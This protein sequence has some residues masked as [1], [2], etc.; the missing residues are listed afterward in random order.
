MISASLRTIFT[1]CMAIALV[2]S[3]VIAEQAEPVVA[4]QAESAPVEV[5]PRVM[6][7]SLEAE[8]TAIDYE[9]RAVSLR[10]PQGNI[11]TIT[12]GENVER[13]QEIAI[14]DTITT[15]YIASLEGELREP[16]EEELANPWAE[17]DGA[18]KASENAEAGAI[19]GRIIRAVCVIEGMNRLLGTVTVKDPRGNYHVIGDVEPEKMEGVLL[20]ATVVLVYTEA[21]AITLEKHTAAE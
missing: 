21:I 14:G 20:G 19:V 3:P 1:G 15:T 16:T 18:A 5:K 13:L 6:T 4:E 17:I 8:V 2:S 7:V 9:T 11:V 10:G 12:A